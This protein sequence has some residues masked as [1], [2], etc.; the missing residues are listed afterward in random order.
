M[1]QVTY[2]A[3]DAERR[4]Q[5]QKWGTVAEHGHTLGGWILLIESELAEAKYALIKGGEGRDSVRAELV[6]V[7][8][9]CVAALEEHG[10]WTTQSPEREL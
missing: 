4:F 8:A 6:Q 5:D 7:A 3:I 10:T 9:L 2:M 1:N